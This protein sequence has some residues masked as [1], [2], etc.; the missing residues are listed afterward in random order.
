MME[1]TGLFIY[2]PDQ[3]GTLSQVGTSSY[4]AYAMQE[5]TKEFQSGSKSSYLVQSMQFYVS[6][7]IVYFSSCAS[8]QSEFTPRGEGGTSK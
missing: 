7:F 2:V 4:M 6:C 1:V 3:I 5:P 8:I